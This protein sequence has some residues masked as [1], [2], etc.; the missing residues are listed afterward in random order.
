MPVQE[1]KHT[2][3]QRKL[4]KIQANRLAGLANVKASE[5]EGLTLAHAADLLKWKVDPNLFFF[6]KIC[7][8]VVKKDPV[9]GIEYPVPFATVYVEDTDCNFI[10]YFPQASPWGWHFPFW[11]HREVIGTT[12][13]DACGNFCVWVPRFDI[14]WI[15]HWRLKRVCFPIIFRRPSLGDLLPKIP[16]RVVG[17]WPPVPGPD[18]G[19]IDILTSLPAATVEALAGNAAGKAAK[20]A[21]RLRAAQSLGSSTEA[22]S[23]LLNRRAFETE[24][25][26]PLPAEFHRAL[27]GERVVAAKGASATEG[28]RANIAMKLGLDPA[29]KEIAKFDPQRFI[30]PF[31]RCYDILVPEWQLILDVPD[32]TFRVTQDV[33]GDGTEE[34]IYSE[35]YFDVRWDAGP[36]P[37]VTLVATVEA[38][39][40]RVCN[41]PA[42]PCGNQPAILFAG[43]M[44][45]TNPS[46]FDAAEGWALRPNRPVPASPPRPPAQTPFCWTLQFY[47]CVDVQGAKFYRV[48]QSTDGGANF[49]AITGLS[50]NNYLNTNGTPIPITADTNGWYAVNPINP[51]TSNPVPRNNLEFPNLLLDWPTPELGKTVLRIEIADAGKVS[52]GFS[53]D[54]A[55]RTDNT[56][57]TVLFNQLAWKFVGEDDSQLRSLLGIPC[58]IIRRGTTAR[59][60]E[61]VFQVS[62][63]ADRLR[64]A[65][66]WPSGC[67]GGSFVYESG[68]TS[69]WHTTVLDNSVT[70]TG[71]YKLSASA[72]EGAYGFNAFAASCAMNPSGA[73]GGSLVPPDFYYDPVYIYVEPSIQVAVVNEN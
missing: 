60:V 30:G 42:V 7:G 9:T 16:P 5:L 66:I 6:R 47:G 67:G 33:N 40:T 50:W 69:H 64:N 55:V 19:P 52:L 38:K 41:A 26:P 21:G 63:S 62:A 54:V 12:K 22:A 3:E 24:L 8:R 10:S 48:Q 31:W 70:L 53:A 29:A 18:P 35:S 44:P 49:S 25:P 61:V 57:P 34:T 72:L 14:D 15:L 20:L 17:P 51:V 27:S 37:D 28:V 59:D 68:T 11:C 39:E 36:L 45:L 73:D 46:Y 13:T 56:A 65:F 2:P 58:P 4:T 1:P 71:R 43:F 32:I 23:G